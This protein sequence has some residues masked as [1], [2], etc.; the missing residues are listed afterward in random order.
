MFE[1]YLLART[2]L[3]PALPRL[4]I[5]KSTTAILVPFRCRVAA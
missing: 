4:D 5:V 3:D 1:T 2:Q